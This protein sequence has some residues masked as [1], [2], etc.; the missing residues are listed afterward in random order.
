MS[1]PDKEDGEGFTVRPIGVAHTPYDD[2]HDAPRQGRMSD[3]EAVIEV[4]EEYAPALKDV[5]LASHLIVLY[6][7]HMARRD[8]LQ[9]V[10]PWGPET[11]GVFACRSP[12]R[13]N[14]ISLCVV[15]LV[16]REGDRLIVRGLDAA[17]GSPVLDIKPYSAHIDGVP[18]AAISWLPAL[19]P[20]QGSETIGAGPAGSGP[21]P[22]RGGPPKT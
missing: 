12:S 7:A 9:T 22:D 19:R 11:R 18:D 8:V 14:P 21:G 2:T 15:E 1:Y 13:P 6:W 17:D 5:E 20:S 16:R 3:A 4:R 10:T